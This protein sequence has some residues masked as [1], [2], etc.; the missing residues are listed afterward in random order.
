MKKVLLALACCLTLTACPGGIRPLH[1]PDK[2]PVVQTDAERAISAARTSIDEAN[3]A[4]LAFDA[5]IDSNIDNKIWDKK[6]AQ[7]YLDQSKA[8]GKRVTQARE[9]LRLGNVTDAKGQAEAVKKLI[10]E[11]Q[12]QVAKR[13]AGG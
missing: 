2:A 7:D 4:L 3:G 6:T 1:D 13:A 8:A 5:V 12:R 10:I 9:A 11:L